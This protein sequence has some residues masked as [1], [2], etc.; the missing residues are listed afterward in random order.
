M[1]LTKS[2]DRMTSGG[3]I[4]VRDFIP[5]GFDFTNNDCTAYIQA[6]YNQCAVN[7]G[8]QLIWP[9][10]TYKVDGTIL[11]ASNIKTDLCG[12]TING[13]DQILFETGYLSGTTILTTVGTSDA[14][15]TKAVFNAKIGNGI[16]QNTS[17]AFKLVKFLWLCELYSI[18]LD[19][20]K[21][22]DGYICFYSNYKELLAAT[23]SNFIGRGQ[24]T[25][26]F[27]SG[28]NT[29][30]VLDDDAS[31][32]SA[33]MT[34]ASYSVPLGTTIASVGA[35]GSGGSGLTNIVLS[36]NAIKTVAKGSSYS[37]Y[38]ATSDTTGMFRFDGNCS[39]TVFEK[40]TV[41]RHW[42]GF[43]VNGNIDG[44]T[45]T[46]CDISFSA[47]GWKFNGGSNGITFTGTYTEQILQWLFDLSDATKPHLDITIGRLYL[48]AGVITCGTSGGV[49]GRLCLTAST[50]ADSVYYGGFTPFA[51][52]NY[53]SLDLT[54]P[55]ANMV[56]IGGADGTMLQNTGSESQFFGQYGVRFQ[57]RN[58]DE[59]QTLDWYEEGTW[60]PEL[61]GY[62]DPLN[63]GTTTYT[64]QLGQFTRIGNCVYFEIELVW[65]GQTGS[66]GLSIY[67]WPFQPKTSMELNV[68]SCN[69]S[70]VTKSNVFVSV[71][72]WSEPWRA[73]IYE[74]DN[75]SANTQVPHATSGSIALTGHYFIQ[76]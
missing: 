13:N 12:S 47:Y 45:F 65:T 66:G 57:N 18:Q 41:A 76:G 31:D 49:Y 56:V 21:M 15:F 8:G 44:C 37:G 62:D 74:S 53:T 52:G 68:T 35:A 6:A 25:A 19:H 10:A 63:D 50:A 20:G 55:N 2:T 46:S 3:P 38:C 5:A 43:E 42:L 64:T 71:I 36:E 23:P 16:I 75:T 26:N 72:A 29:I 40:C 11:F 34:F 7:G 30:T 61:L 67:N 60:E 27:T 24:P 58:I 22:I 28:S 59:P 51:L 69:I 17:L 32:L 9:Q 4:N 70:T 73:V 1:A 54:S 33:G 39:N 48:C 14:D